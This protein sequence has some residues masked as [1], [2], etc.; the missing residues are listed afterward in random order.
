M[1]DVD[2]GTRAL[3]DNSAGCQ[4]LKVGRRNRGGAPGRVVLRCFV[5][6]TNQSTRAVAGLP[7][8][9][10]RR[11]RSC[12]SRWDKR[13]GRMAPRARSGRLPGLVVAN[14]FQL[15]DHRITEAACHGTAGPQANRSELGSQVLCKRGL[16]SGPMGPEAFWGVEP[17]SDSEFDVTRA[18]GSGRLRPTFGAELVFDG[19]THPRPKARATTDDL[20]SVL[21]EAKGRAGHTAVDL[22]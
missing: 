3:M 17:S 4:R 18:T 6:A 5:G 1:E 21:A 9:H 22:G 15:C 2:A 8:G 13:T 11:L 7:T 19:E 14:P 20:I 12:W 16:P 10:Q